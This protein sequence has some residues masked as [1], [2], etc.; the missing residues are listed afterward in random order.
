MRDPN[1]IINSELVFCFTHTSQEQ[2]CQV[3][4]VSGS[5]D[6]LHFLISYQSSYFQQV[7]KL[8]AIG[9]HF[10][11]RLFSRK[12]EFSVFSHET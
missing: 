3:Q 6:F 5:Y 7:I 4:S 11:S 8:T 10:I 1:S 2:A 9:C 12:I